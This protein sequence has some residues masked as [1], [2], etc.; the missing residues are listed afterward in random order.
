VSQEDDR[1]P[2]P[3]DEEERRKRAAELHEQIE[4]LKSG[5]PPDELARPAHPSPREFT[6]QSVREELEPKQPSGEDS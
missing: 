5:V 3:S 4:Q 1:Q 2:S 6:E